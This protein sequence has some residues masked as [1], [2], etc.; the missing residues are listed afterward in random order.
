M[1]APFEQAISLALICKVDILPRRSLSK[2]RL[3]YSMVWNF[4][5]KMAVACY[6]GVDTLFCG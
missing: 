1:D 3:K 4:Y 6:F 2:D 5:M